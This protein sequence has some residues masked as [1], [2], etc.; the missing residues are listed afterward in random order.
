MGSRTEIMPIRTPRKLSHDP[1]VEAVFELRFESN[2]P[3]AADLLVGTVFARFKDTFPRLERLPF[4]EFPRQLQELDKNLRYQPRVKLEGDKFGIFLGDR[5]ALVSCPRP[6]QGWEEFREV[7][8]LFLEVVKGTGFI[9]QI[10]RFSLKY[11]NLLPAK[12]LSEQ[13]AL[14]KYGAQLGDF[15]LTASVTNTRTELILDNILNLVE[16]QP[17]TNVTIKSGDPSYGLLLTV[18]SINRET[19]EFWENYRDRLEH[20]HGVEKQVFFGILSQAA[21][22]QFRPIWE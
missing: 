7:I 21:L 2:V 20:L 13:F 18:D 15:D 1:I 8:F 10:E 11:V 4:S 9:K 3:A 22:D 19:S 12:A 14:I 16:V 17:S 5:S 6:Y